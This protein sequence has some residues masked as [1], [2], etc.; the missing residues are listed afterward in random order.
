MN[1]TLT[2]VI[3]LLAFAGYNG[4]KKGILRVAISIISLVVTLFLTIMLAP[5]LSNV[6]QE[7]TPIYSKI[8]DTVYT[9]VQKNDTMQEAAQDTLT[10]D[11]DKAQDNHAISAYL[12]QFAMQL[13]LPEDMVAYF[14]N[15]FSE[16]MKE[17]I[18][19]ETQDLKQM[20]L[21][22]FAMRL[23]SVI[24]QCL[25]HIIVFIVVYIIVKILTGTLNLIGRLPVIHTLNNLG[26]CALGVAEGCVIIWLLFTVAAVCT[27]M[28]WAVWMNTQI[29]ESSFLQWIQEHN[30]IM[31]HLLN[32]L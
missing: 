29:A 17:Q 22:A 24:Y 6:I 30:F 23:A 4:W 27:N 13:N 5:V 1:I 18:Q 3:V 11:D 12:E 16:A 14:Q 21:Y 2:A 15:D 9:A 10:Q 32:T 25:I 7:H 8:Q 19:A 20:V 26:G 31:Q 28:Q